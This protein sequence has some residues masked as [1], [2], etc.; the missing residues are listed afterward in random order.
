MNVSSKLVSCLRGPALIAGLILIAAAAPANAQTTIR[1]TTTQG[2]PCVAVT[3][4]NGLTLIPGGTDLQATGVTL[5]GAGCGTQGAPPPT[6]PDGLTLT[7]TPATPG[8]GVAFSVSWQVSNAS[9]CVGTV[10]SGT[11]AN[12]AGWTEVSTA[13]SP[14]SVTISAAG[15]Y[16]LKLTCS[17]A[18]NPTN[19]VSP[20][21]PL[22]VGD[23]SAC[24][25]PGLTRLV[26]SDIS[27]GAYP[28]PVR[29][30]VDVREW[31]NLW[32]H[33]T[34]TDGAAPWP[35]RSGSGPN[36]TQF[37]R[38]DFVAAHFRTPAASTAIGFFSYPESFPG[39]NIDMKISTA[40]GDFTPNTA[41]PACLAT[42]V[43]SSGV[44]FL[45]WN[46]TGGSPNFKCQLQTNTDYYVNM[47]MTD[48]NSPVEC[49]TGSPICPIEVS[50]NFSQ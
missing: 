47:K 11:A 20:T 43:F 6:S 8:A 12:V 31:D 46:F 38:H 22:S 2:L 48:P 13:T 24:T 26:T 34:A 40:C 23:G 7:A 1:M 10:T 49:A 50:D 25:S 37:G 9:T 15:T 35:G 17:N 42:N 28:F 3:D 36:I 44:S 27:Y 39:P 19:L 32:A 14:R 16:G 18:G 5:T 21:L 4:A 29:P 33:F 30:A 41:N 45:Y